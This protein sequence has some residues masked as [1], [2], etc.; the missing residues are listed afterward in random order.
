LSW[1]HIG[2]TCG[3]RIRG[4][5]ACYGYRETRIKAREEIEGVVRD[6]CVDIR[7]IKFHVQGYIAIDN[8]GPIFAIF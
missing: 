8:G 7:G 5:R 2:P 1:T 6:G 4:L 3:V